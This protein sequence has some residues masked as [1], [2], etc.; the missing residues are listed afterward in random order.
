M[1]R[2]DDLLNALVALTSDPLSSDLAA[3]LLLGTSG[4]EDDSSSYDKV[5]VPRS[6]SGCSTGVFSS[7]S[8]SAVPLPPTPPS[9]RWHNLNVTLPLYIAHGT[10][11][12]TD[13]AEG[14]NTYLFSRSNEAAERLLFSSNGQVANIWATCIR[15]RIAVLHKCP[16][17]AVSA[18]ASAFNDHLEDFRLAG[19]ITL[20]CRGLV[21]HKIQ[22]RASGGVSFRYDTVAD[23]E[24]EEDHQRLRLLIQRLSVL[25]SK[26]K[27]FGEQGIELRFSPCKELKIAVRE[28]DTPCP[29]PIIDSQIAGGAAAM[30]PWISQ[31]AVNGLTANEVRLEIDKS[32]NV[33][34]DPALPLLKCS[35][36][37]CKDKRGNWARCVFSPNVALPNVIPNFFS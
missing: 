13:A 25:K 24:T 26:L 12:T 17:Q 10:I 6:S 4:V 1:Y 19:P 9:R 16:E 33:H 11:I 8:S 32:T 23:F 5:V 18:V 29:D 35:K 34:I 27:H 22:L 28:G 3:L 15:L 36:E 14:T 30:G 21:K 31:H 37:L 2:P 20:K 7:C